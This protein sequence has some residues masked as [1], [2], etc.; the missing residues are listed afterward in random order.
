[1][2]TALDKG[3]A[4]L[5]D[6]ISQYYLAISTKNVEAMNVLA[7]KVETEADRVGYTNH[8]R[9]KHIHTLAEQASEDA[10]V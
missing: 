5:E 8:G 3:P 7:A 2:S 1:M 6:L 9:L 4:S 10:G